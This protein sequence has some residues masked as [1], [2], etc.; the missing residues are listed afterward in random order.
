MLPTIDPTTTKSWKKLSNYFTSI[1]KQSLNQL[2]ESDNNRAQK[3][4]LQWQNLF[5]DYSKTHIDEQT[6]RLLIE[7]ARECH[8]AEAIEQMFRGEKINQTQKRAV[9]HFALRNLGDD[10]VFLDGRDVM[11][12]IRTVRNQMKIFST[13]VRNGD[14][15]GYTGKPIRNIVNIGIGGSDL[16]P[17]MVCR[18]LQFYGHERLRVFFVSNV[19]GGHIYETLRHLNAEETLFLIVSKSFTTQET[20]ANAKT[21]RQWFI[22]QGGK[23]ED[24]SKHFVAISTN[25]PAAMEFGID[26]EN[27]FHFW[28]Y[29]GGRFS[30]WSAVGLSIALQIGYESYEE[31]LK[32][33]EAMD[34]HFR[35]TPFENNLP[36]L[37]ALLSIWYTNFF[38]CA[39]EA[40]L[41]YDQ[42]LERFPAY[43]QQTIMESNGKSIDRSGLP[44]S[45][46][47]SPVIWGEPGTNGQ[48]SFYQLIH[49]G[50]Q[51]IP[52][53]FMA[54]AKP[55]TPLSEHHQLLLSN[56]FAQPEALMKGKTAE[57]VRAEMLSKGFN[58]EEI[59]KLLPFRVFR[60]NIPSISLL[61]QQL[62]P[63]N[64]GAITAL[65]EH[66]TFV[67]GI[68]WNIFS[69][70]QWG[71]ELGKSLANN[72]IPELAHDDPIQTHDGS[73][74]QLIHK[75][76]QM[77]KS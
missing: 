32:G 13:Q 69:F 34:H 7:L 50:T 39:T 74:R 30:L 6:M 4:S 48:H 24:I 40:I 21:A 33:A 9:L 41:P 8:L 51:M 61:Y 77:R 35:E 66:R 73:T 71:V 59:N 38:D 22:N 54:A 14:W 53:I 60:G 75:V 46:K 55:L 25:T 68:I 18:G 67:Q 20:L 19:D 15:K 23:A 49:Q 10:P 31:L 2:F 42:Y 57:E 1:G 26:P 12:E 70:D 27:I 37:L 72:I 58:E 3:F 29:V 45:Y 16:G 17:A 43:L 36:I 5:V 11:P 28:D 56:F 63:Y 52:C 62:T 65:F 64:L 76:K 47:T 44:V